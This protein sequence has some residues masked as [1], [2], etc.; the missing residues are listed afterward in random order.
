[1]MVSDAWRSAA[2]CRKADRNGRRS[3]RISQP[4]T[5]MD[6]PLNGEQGIQ[7][8]VATEDSYFYLVGTDARATELATEGIESLVA[9]NQSDHASEA[10]R[11]ALIPVF[12]VDRHQLRIESRE[13]ALDGPHCFSRVRSHAVT[14]PAQQD[15]VVRIG[16]R[17]RE[18]EKLSRPLCPIRHGPACRFPNLVLGELFTGDARGLARAIQELHH[19][20]GTGEARDLKAVANPIPVETPAR[21]DDLLI[22]A[23]GLELPSEPGLWHRRLD[24]CL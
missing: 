23:A 3:R 11:A 18:A 20:N 8:Q 14:R 4:V 16:A 12:G 22:H 13:P 7:I 5:R 1:M 21:G 9:H 6:R 17:A 15:A 19:G 24:R 2:A 10:A